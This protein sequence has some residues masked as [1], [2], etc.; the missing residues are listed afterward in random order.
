MPF[1]PPLRCGDHQLDAFVLEHQAGT[2]HL[3]FRLELGSGLSIFWA[4]PAGRN[5]RL[6]L[7]HVDSAAYELDEPQLM[8]DPW[9]A[10]L[11]PLGWEGELARIDADRT[12]VS[13]L[14]EMSAQ[15]ARYRCEVRLRHATGAHEDVIFLWPLAD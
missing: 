5:D 1:R 7:V 2:D 6:R 9:T 3:D 15:P 8:A 11:G 4:L 13:V 10:D 14:F 12:L